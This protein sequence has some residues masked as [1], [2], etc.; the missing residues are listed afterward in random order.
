[1]AFDILGLLDCLNIN[2][3][4]LV[5]WGDRGIIGL[6]LAIKH[7]DFINKLVLIGASTHH[8]GLHENFMEMVKLATADNWL[9]PMAVD[10]YKKIAPDPAHVSVLIEKIKKLWLTE[11]EYTQK[12][13]SSIKAPTLIITSKNEELINEE[14]TKN[15]AQTI[16]NAKLD[17]IPNSGHFCPVEDPKTVNRL[18]IDFLG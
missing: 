13:I 6:E 9:E 4:N 14:H 1:M 8:E 15:I 10:M 18:I 3:T 17:L 5:G 12:E 16:P 7:P 2:K 11:P